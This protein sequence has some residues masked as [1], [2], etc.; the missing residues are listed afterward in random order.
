MIT[1]FAHHGV[2]DYEKWKHAADEMANSDMNAQMGIVDET[3]YRTADGS[4]VVVMNT[5]R[6]LDDAKKFKATMESPE[7]QAM[8]EQSGGQYPITIWITEKA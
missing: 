4:G 7:T 8:I 5:F 3:I 6:S 2:T 1:L